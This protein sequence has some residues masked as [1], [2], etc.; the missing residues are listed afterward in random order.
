M[1]SNEFELVENLKT[2]YY[3]F[4]GCIV[5]LFI[6]LT[7][8]FS[9]FPGVAFI[10]F[11]IFEGVLL[12]IIVPLSVYAYS[13]NKWVRYVLSNEKF[14]IIKPK[15]I[16]F[17]I[18]WSEFDAMK[19]KA[20]GKEIGSLKPIEL[21]RRTNVFKIKFLIGPDQQIIKSIK[22]A[23]LNRAKARQLMDAIIEYTTNKGKDVILKKRDL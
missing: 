22:F 11:L 2:R 18:S 6:I 17:E 23:I 10:Y 21:Q 16:R 7:I 15:K 20:L 13:R 9:G 5:G 8:A 14:M 4:F 19:L 3:I 12:A 1:E